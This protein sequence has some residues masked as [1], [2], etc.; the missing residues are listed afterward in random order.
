MAAE[1]LIARAETAA[2]ETNTPL[3]QKAF[4]R[5]KEATAGKKIKGL[6]SVGWE[7]F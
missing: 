5:G 1:G 3:N 6:V 2:Q 4:C 7:K